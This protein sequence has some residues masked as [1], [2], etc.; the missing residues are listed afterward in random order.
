M[1]VQTRSG[2]RSRERAH[3]EW[4][5]EVRGETDLQRLD[6]NF[7]EILQELRV[8]QTGVQILFAFLL[9]LAFTQRFTEITAFQRNLYLATLLLTAAATGLLIAPVGYHRIT[10]RRRMRP[11]L[12]TDANLLALGGLTFLMLALASSVLFITDVVLGRGPAVVMTVVVTLWFVVLWYLL[13]AARLVQRLDNGGA[14]PGTERGTRSGAD[15]VADRD[16]GE[17]SAEPEPEAQ[18]SR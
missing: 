14:D 12:V 1:A 10:F 6:R 8:A 11:Q 2:A 3:D 9:T 16:D 17:D 15:P 4:N 13:P 18:A 7:G 5:E